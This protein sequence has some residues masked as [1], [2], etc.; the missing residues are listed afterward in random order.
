MTD[1][2]A[3]LQTACTEFTYIDEFSWCGVM[4]WTGTYSSPLGPHFF[5]L[6]TEECTSESSGLAKYNVQYWSERV[7][8]VP[9]LKREFDSPATFPSHHHCWS[10]SAL[11]TWYPEASV[12]L[13]LFY[14][15]FI[16]ESS[17]DM[18]SLFCT[19]V[20]WCTVVVCYPVGDEL[21]ISHII[22]S[23]TCFC[24]RPDF[25]SVSLFTLP[26]LIY[27]LPALWRDVFLG[28]GEPERT[29]VC[30]RTFVPQ[31][32]VWGLSLALRPQHSRAQRGHSTMELIQT[33]ETQAQE[34]GLSAGPRREGS[35]ASR[36]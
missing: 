28:R 18:F 31:R 20:L 14:F 26:P 35:R 30:E 24:F 19:H 17:T 36:R 11:Y 21:Y 32:E 9:W 22:Q 1:V 3:H 34:P 5:Q 25:I 23:L 33:W 16:A 2:D 8:I 27:L 10:E 15:N 29:F 13:H 4:W 12:F 7:L 6:I